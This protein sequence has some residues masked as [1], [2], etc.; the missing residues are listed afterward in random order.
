MTMEKVV[1][2][3]RCL[4]NRNF[5]MHSATL[6][7]ANIQHSRPEYAAEH[8]LS[9]HSSVRVLLFNVAHARRSSA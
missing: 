4:R 5:E 2:C 1:G 6:S 3:C 7:P 9:C 8:R